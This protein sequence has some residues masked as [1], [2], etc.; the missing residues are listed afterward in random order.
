MNDTPIRWRDDPQFRSSSGIDM[1]AADEGLGPFNLDLVRAKAFQAPLG[2]GWTPGVGVAVLAVGVGAAAWLAASEAKVPPQLPSESPPA[3][4]VAVVTPVAPP[5]QPPEVPAVLEVPAG[6]LDVPLASPRSGPVVEAV[7]AQAD[8]P[9]API[10]VDEVS[11]PV[12]VPR[13][14]LDGLAAQMAEYDRARGLERVGHREAALG[15]Y[16]AWLERWPD[17]RLGTEV[18][19]ARVQL[20][21]ALGRAVEAEVAAA[22]VIPTVD[23]AGVRQQLSSLRAEALSGLDR[24]DEALLLVDALSDEDA[25]A[26]RKRCRRR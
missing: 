17:G 15:A 10:A 19:L 1:R 20:L 2:L 13:P 23:A 25:A 22:H 7:A 4:S 11:S 12:D 5:V 3:H 14:V 16:E 8:L 26:V 18:Q 24:C 9:P 6:S 21:M